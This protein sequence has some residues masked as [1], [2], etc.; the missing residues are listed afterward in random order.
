[1][2]EEN[3]KIIID[4]VKLNRSLLKYQSCKLGSRNSYKINILYGHDPFYFQ[5]AICKI[6]SIEYD[7][8][9]HP[10]KYDIQLNIDHNFTDYK[11]LNIMDLSIKKYMNE[12]NDTHHLIDEKLFDKKF[13][14]AYKQDYDK[15]I[16]KFKVKLNQDCK[17]YNL[18]KRL[19][20]CTEIKK[21]DLIIGLLYINGIFIDENGINYRY[22]ADQI[23]KIN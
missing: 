17:Y 23:V 21:N 16:L 2:S 4:K 5:S 14:S 10:I 13:Y 9:D 1:M 20:S 12:F 15:N 3:K 6:N 11:F 19:I 8:H 7:K 22:T 18:S